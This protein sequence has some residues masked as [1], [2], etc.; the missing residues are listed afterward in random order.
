[1]DLKKVLTGAALAASLGLGGAWS[2]VDRFEPAADMTK[3]YIDPVGIRTICRGTTGPLARQARVTQAQCDEATVSDLRTA[4]ATVR[5]CYTG[6]LTNGELNAWTSFTLNVG[7]GARGVKDGF[8][9]LKSGAVPSHLRLLNT[10]R[11]A[12]ACAVLMQWTSAGGRRLQGLYNR[13]IAELALCL[14]DLPEGAP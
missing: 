10:H 2:I 4:E 11:P 12:A 5:R 1:M 3:S 8:C 7:P 14:R 9:I 13:R 6:P